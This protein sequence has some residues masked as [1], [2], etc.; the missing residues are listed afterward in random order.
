MNEY[1]SAAPPHPHQILDSIQSLSFPTQSAEG[2]YRATW[3]FHLQVRRL[4]GPSLSLN[5][6]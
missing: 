4:N 5:L 3:F 2:A 6:N 1:N